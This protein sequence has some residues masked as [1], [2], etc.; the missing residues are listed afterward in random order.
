MVSTRIT[1]TLTYTCSHFRVGFY[2]FPA[3]SD[4]PTGHATAFSK[5]IKFSFN[6]SRYDFDGSLAL[7]HS[8]NTTLAKSFEK[9]DHGFTNTLSVPNDNGD[10]GGY[11]FAIGWAGGLH[12]ALQ[13]N[14]FYTNGA[15][16]VVKDVD[17]KREIVEFREAGNIMNTAPMPPTNDWACAFP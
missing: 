6:G 16:A 8:F 10:K 1:T 14:L 17:G 12:R 9:F 2:P 15:F 3:N 5:D 13:R 7:Y 4:W 11:V